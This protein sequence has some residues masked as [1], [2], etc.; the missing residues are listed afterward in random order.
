M[1]KIGQVEGDDGEAPGVGHN[2]GEVLNQTAQGQLASF[3]ERIERLNEEI[4]ETRELV[5][6]VKAEAK[7]SGYD[8]PILMLLIK[9]RAMDR[10]KGQERAAVLDLYAAALGD[11]SLADLC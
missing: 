6:E 4:A 3:V 9:R 10:A 2:S 8:V 7:G 11:P 5:K 1:A